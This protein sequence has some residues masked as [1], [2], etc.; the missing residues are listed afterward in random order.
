MAATAG[1]GGISV[2]AECAPAKRDAAGFGEQAEAGL[3]LHPLKPT[4]GCS[5]TG[6]LQFG[7]QAAQQGE[8]LLLAESDETAGLL[9]GVA[10]KQ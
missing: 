5:S 6:A 4:E 10:S 2:A 7:V 1:A 8:T 3:D 9:S